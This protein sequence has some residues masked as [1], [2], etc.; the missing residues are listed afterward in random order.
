MA[1]RRFATA[2]VGLAFL[3]AVAGAEPISIGLHSLEGG[4]TATVSSPLSTS[5]FQL[6]AITLPDVNSAVL[7]SV[8][9]LPANTNFL[10]EILVHGATSTW[11]TLRAEVLDPLDDDDSLDMA[12]Y[13][14]GVPVGFSTSNTRD[15]FSFAQSA[16]LERSVVFAGGSGSVS[17]D[18]DSNGADVLFF[19]G[20]AGASDALRVRF[21]LRDYDGDR[22]FLVRLSAQDAIATPEPA[23]MILIGTG[24]AGLMAARRRRR[25]AE[26]T[27]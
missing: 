17:A 25:A 2:L 26:R 11:N 16:G 7:L 14:A 20:V 4:A 6:G 3:P 21:G 24:L 19:G 22:S 13:H 27:T 9:G 1:T 8:T 15:G 18:E 23:S 5:P 10:M 12:P